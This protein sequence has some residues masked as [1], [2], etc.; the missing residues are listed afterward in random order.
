MI[1]GQYKFSKY[2]VYVSF[3]SVVVLKYGDVGWFGA[4]I[5]RKCSDNP[6]WSN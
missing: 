6:Q 1:K 2:L 4:Q 5:G 3:V